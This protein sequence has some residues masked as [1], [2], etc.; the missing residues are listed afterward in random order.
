MHT[1]Q[2]AERNGGAARAGGSGV[3]GDRT[4]LHRDRV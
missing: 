4:M 3:E 1:I 2:I